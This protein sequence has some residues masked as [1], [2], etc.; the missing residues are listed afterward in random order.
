MARVFPALLK[1]W[2]ARRG[3][4]QLDFALAAELSSRHLSFLET[5]RAR[6]SEDMV[7][8]LAHAL[9]LSLR[10]RN[11]LL[12]A[13]GYAARF[14]APALDAL[15]AP[16]DWA[17]ARMLAQQEPYPLM[18]LSA[19]HDVVRKN[20]AADRLLRDFVADPARLPEVPNMCDVVFDPALARPFLTNW[21]QLARRMLSRLQL[22]AL[23]APGGPAGDLVARMLRHPG[24]PAG[25]KQPDF[26]VEL[27][28]TLTVGLARDGRR[29]NFLTTITLF[30]APQSVTLEELRIESYFPLDDDTRRA[31]EPTRD[32]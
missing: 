12:E 25:W 32:G 8:R 3:Q 29:L 9:E 7:L 20:R 26:A 19:G 28:S 13:A 17:L 24:V 23:R 22:E 11:E 16:V 14:P 18:V 21:T 15:P 31:C 10:E 1:Y 6:P 5:G 30:S 4:S 27:A 2:R